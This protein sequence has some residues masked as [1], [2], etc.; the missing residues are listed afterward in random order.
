M[1]AVLILNRWIDPIGWS[2]IAMC[3]VYIAWIFWLDRK[4]DRHE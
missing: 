2:V 4:A 1:D 3:M